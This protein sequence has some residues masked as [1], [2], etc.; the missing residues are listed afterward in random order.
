MTNIDGDNG[1][2]QQVPALRFVSLIRNPI[3]I[4]PNAHSMSRTLVNTGDYVSAR[5]SNR[6]SVSPWTQ[7][8]A[9]VDISQCIMRERPC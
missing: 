9:A 1:S 5:L 3:N 2:D 8:G 7:I 6:D 4:A